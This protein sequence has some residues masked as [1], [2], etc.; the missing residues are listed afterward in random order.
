MK[1]LPLLLPALLTLSLAA[2]VPTGE[3]EWR[4]LPVGGGE[5]PPAQ[6]SQP[7]K[8]IAP[9]ADRMLQDPEEDIRDDGVEVV[10]DTQQKAENKCQRIAQNLSGQDAVVTCLGCR[11]RTKTTGK[12]IC[13]LRTESR[14]VPPRE[15]QP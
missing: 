13:T 2:C 1:Q 6:S 4:L 14:S 7:S 3:G 5:A 12:F 15:S 8:P 10:A 9:G 11:P